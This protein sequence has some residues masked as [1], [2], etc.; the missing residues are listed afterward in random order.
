MFIK[1]DDLIHS[2]IS[3]NKWRKLKYNLIKAKSEGR[4]SLLT[5]GGAYSNHLVATAAAAELHGLRSIGIVR[6]NE[7]DSE[8]NQTLKRCTEYGMELLFVSREEYGY[9]TEKWYKEELAA[10]FPS[11]LIIDEGGSGYFGMI[12]CQEILKEIDV[13]YDIVVVAQ[14]TST[15][16][17]GLLLSLP[18]HKELWGVPVMKGY[19]SVEE[20][21]D[22]F[23]STAIE[24]EMIEDLLNTYR[25]L[26]DY[27]FNGYARYD[28]DLLNFIANFWKEYQL[29]LDP[30]YTGKAMYGLIHETLKR[31][32]RNKNLLFIHTGGLQGAR[33]IFEK[34][35]RDI[36]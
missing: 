2:E 24:A 1:R 23:S 35:K 8:S 33:S 30:V 3:G 13:Q 19:R 4:T 14:G 12:G 32:L 21:K 18:D 36:F 10:K 6:G 29:P 31:G 26:D 20:L 11:A 17:A 15:T 5:F 22:L 28:N 34:E 25:P 16:A 9:R 7:L 27:H